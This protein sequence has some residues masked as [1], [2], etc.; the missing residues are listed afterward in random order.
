MSE[1]LTSK[2][3]VGA[4]SLL[5]NAEGE[6]WVTLRESD[7][8]NLIDEFERLQRENDELNEASAMLEN[9]IGNL[10]RELAAMKTAYDAVHQGAQDW[11][12]RALKAESQSG[13]S[14]DQPSHRS[15][16][17]TPRGSLPNSLGAEYK[18]DQEWMDTSLGEPSP[19]LLASDW[20]AEARELLRQTT[21]DDG[22]ISMAE[23]ERRRDALLAT[24]AQP[25]CAVPSSDMIALCIEME[26][27][28]RPEVEKEPDRSF[29]W[30]LVDLN[31][32]AKSRA[33]Q[34]SKP[35]EEFTDPDG[36]EVTICPTCRQGHIG[37]SRE[38]LRKALGLGLTKPDVTP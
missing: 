3:L 2:E 33:A 8:K 37:S 34:P 38:E 16:A 13:K 24:P 27:W 1:P 15:P 4:L 28:L 26:D 18:P 35:V 12:Q 10:Q 20:V 21:F 9:T 22:A 23:W 17:P 32:K 31:K 19:Q 7:A 30:R 29:F 6:P 5:R 14:V 25:P 36:D 11:M